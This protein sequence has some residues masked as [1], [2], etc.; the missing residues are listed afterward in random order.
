MPFCLCLLA[1]FF[2]VLFLCNSGWLRIIVFITIQQLFVCRE[3]TFNDFVGPNPVVQSD[4]NCTSVSLFV[5]TY[6]R[7]HNI[8]TFKKMQLPKAHQA[9]KFFPFFPPSTFH[10]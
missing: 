9:T 1:S 10:R 7:V 8:S 3:Q 5:R 6:I 2:A 4:M